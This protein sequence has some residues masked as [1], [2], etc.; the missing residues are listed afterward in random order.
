MRVSE[1]PFRIFRK[2][3]PRLRERV[4]AALGAAGHAHSFVNSWRARRL[5]ETWKQPKSIVSVVEAMLDAVGCR[6][7]DGYRVMEYGS[8]YLLADPLVYTMFGAKE[9][10]AVDYVR[11]LQD[12]VFRDYARDT[13]W[14]PFAGA[15]AE[16][17]GRAAAAAWFDNLSEA[18]SHPGKDWFRGLGISYIAPFDILV[19]DLPERDYDL[20]VSQSTL[21]HAPEDLAASIVA[22]LAAGVKSGGAMHHYIHLADH[23][24]IGGNPLAFL[25][26][27]DDYSSSQHDLRGN[28]MRA[29]DWRGIFSALDFDWSERTKAATPDR[30]PASIADRFRGYDR[31][32]LL[33]VDYTVHGHRH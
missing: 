24:D 4:K 11:L 1:F 22:R 32:D 17:R 26:A 29:S 13:D 16:R 30:L 19:D 23:R 31:D 2:L 7:L 18:L 8:G 33:V 21:E 15:I 6:S 12:K 5:R 27:A 20:V 9:V 10:H 14:R 28:R 25:S 3:P